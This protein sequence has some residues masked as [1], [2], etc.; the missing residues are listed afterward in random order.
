ME[1]ASMQN[2]AETDVDFEDAT[3][4]TAPADY[5]GDG[6]ITFNEIKRFHAEPL[7]CKPYADVSVRQSGGVP[8]GGTESREGIF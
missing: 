5:D 6:E 4:G 3:I 2:F 8:A 7:C 1:T